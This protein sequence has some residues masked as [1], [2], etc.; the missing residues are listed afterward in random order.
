MCLCIGVVTGR[1]TVL[2]DMLEILICLAEELAT[3]AIAKG[4]FGIL[5]KKEEQ[6]S[7]YFPHIKQ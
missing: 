4:V 6:L 7:Y 2:R 1:T 3:E 5:K